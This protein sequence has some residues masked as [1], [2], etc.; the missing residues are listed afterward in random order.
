M[1]VHVQMVSTPTHVTVWMVTLVQ[2][3]RQVCHVK[4]IC[5]YEYPRNRVYVY[6]KKYS[7]LLFHQVTDFIFVTGVLS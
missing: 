1:E 5:S 2:T 6:L 4:A 3:V 7:M